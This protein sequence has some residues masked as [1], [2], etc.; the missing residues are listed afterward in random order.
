[1][2]DT[3]YGPVTDWATDFDHGAP[4]YNANIH[5]IWDDLKAA[6]CPIAHTERYGG[7]WLPLTHDL[8]KEIAY[9]PTR[10]SSLTPV[11]QQLKPSQARELDPDA[12]G[13]PIGPV[14]PISSDPPFHADARRILLPAFSPKQ[15]DPWRSEVEQICNKLID[16]MGDADIIDAAVQYT[17]HIP[18]LVVAQMVGLPLSDADRFRS[19]VD[20]VL[21]GIGAERNEER[22][23]QFEAMDAYLTKHIE[24]HIENPRDDLTTYL[25]NSEIFG[26]KLSPRHVFGTILLLIIAGIDTTWS[27]I[28]SSLWHL[29]SNPVDRRRLV[30]NPEK[31]PTAVEEFL[32]AYAPVTMARMVTDDMEFH[33]VH[34][35]KEDRVLLP[36]PAANRDEKQFANP[37][38]VD[39]ERE[40][41]RHA[42]FGLGIHRCIGSNL[43]RLEMNVAIE[44]FLKRFPDF[45]L[46]N[47]E[48]VTWSSGQ[49][50]GPRNLPFRI[51]VRA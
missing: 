42:A 4:E 32:R 6:G 31:I 38:V 34:M 1:M 37:A 23:A 12:L 9:D 43:A 27:G 44:V 5:Q 16:D 22:L 33:G 11:V 10:F 41:N 36:F 13:A 47:S 19:W 24:D 30:E 18:V 25:L 3:V 46:D 28:G 20:M 40:E 17:Q 35:K 48:Q 26:E 15:I 8:V 49:V 7:V 14:P 2:T 45:E 21:G 39:I 50:R 29:A 51:N